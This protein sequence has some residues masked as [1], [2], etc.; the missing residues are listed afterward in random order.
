MAK[1]HAKRSLKSHQCW[2]IRICSLWVLPIFLSDCEQTFF[3]LP[4]LLALFPIKLQN[5]SVLQG[6]SAEW[7]SAWEASSPSLGCKG[8]IKCKFVWITCFRSMKFYKKT[9]GTCSLSLF[10]FF[11]FG[12]FRAELPAYGGS[13]ARGWIRAAATGLHYSHGSVESE[14]HMWPTH[15][16]WQRPILNPLCKGRDWTHI[17]MDAGWVH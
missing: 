7:F 6:D 2:S 1:S 14:S 8:S 5:R 4:L 12:L 3:F 9:R 13:Q 17:L 11:F 15:S 16:S 10:F